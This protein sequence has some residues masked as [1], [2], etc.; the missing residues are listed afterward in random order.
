MSLVLI[1]FLSFIILG[2]LSNTPSIKVA[3]TGMKRPEVYLLKD[4]KVKREVEDY[5]VY[6]QEK[7]SKIWNVSPQS[8]IPYF[9][10][11]NYDNFYIYS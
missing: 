1:P 4:N 7:D 9:D 3:S 11:I 6:S 5:Q 10:K 8:N 2:P